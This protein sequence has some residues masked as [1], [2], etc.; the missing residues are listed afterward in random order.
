MAKKKLLCK[1]E[2]LAATVEKNGTLHFKIKFS[3]PQK[4]IILTVPK[5]DAVYRL[6]SFS[7]HCRVV[8]VKRNLFKLHET[9]KF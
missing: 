3:M 8:G 9:N 5:K 2:F 4:Q 7:L 1:L 6:P